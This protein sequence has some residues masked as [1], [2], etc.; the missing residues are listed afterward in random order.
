MNSEIKSED[1][2]IPIKKIIRIIITIILLFSATFII[3]G[4]IDWWQGW[5]LYGITMSIGTIL[6]VVI[7]KRHPDLIKE[8]LSD[9][10]NIKP[11]DRIIIKIFFSLTVISIIVGAIDSGRFRWSQMPVALTLTGAVILLI[12]YIIGAWAT[13]ENKFFSLHVRIQDDRGHRVCT[14]GPYRYVRHPGYLSGILMW[15]SY[16][17]ILGSWWASIPD[18]LLIILFIV[19]TILEDRTLQEELEGYKE[20]TKMT[21]YRLFPGI[22]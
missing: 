18:S 13:Y 21:P 16:P 2:G 4:R 19:R 17:L 12:A 7:R 8:R 22:W 14:K 15:I 20:Y 1:P 9:H 6:A 10:E 3:A 5:L 11:W